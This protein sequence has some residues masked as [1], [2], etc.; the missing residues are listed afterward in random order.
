MEYNYKPVNIDYIKKLLTPQKVK[1]VSSGKYR[2]ETN[3]G[4]YVSLGFFV[5]LE[6]AQKVLCEYKYEQLIL[7][8]KEYNLDILDA[9]LLN[10]HYLIFKTGDIFTLKGHK[11]IGYITK[12]GYQTI[13]IDYKTVFAHRIIAMA[14]IDN[15]NNYPF[16]NH[17]DGNKLNNNI[18]NLEWCTSSQNVQ[19][20][21]DTGLH[22]PAVGEDWH[23][24]KL[25]EEQVK[26]IKTHCVKYDKN[27]SATALGKLFN[28][29]DTTIRS[30]VNGKNWKHVVVNK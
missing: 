23:R 19:H 27:F 21:Y 10:D 9:K 8:L 4:H 20:S 5:N 28:V 25:T 12:K 11:L 22:V 16:I 6:D 30:I 17:K 1:K 3:Y 2:A 7:R 26:Y 13:I 15:P 18:E 14:F 29:S 24:H